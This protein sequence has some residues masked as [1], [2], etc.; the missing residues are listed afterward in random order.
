MRNERLRHA[1]VC[2]CFM[3]SGLAALVYQMTWTRQFA[4]VF[5]T[6]ELAVATVLAAYMGGL[7]LGARG[8]EWLLPRVR[9]PLRLYSHL[10]LAIALTAL[11]LVP[12]CLWLAERLIVAMLGGQPEPASSGATGNTVFYLL[13]AFATLLIPTTL[14]GATLPLLAR[15]G[16]LSE[17]QIG[18]RIGMLYACN[19]AGAVVGALF[20]AL[21]LLPLLGL[22]ATTWFAAA[23]NLAVFVLAT[24]LLRIGGERSPAPPAVAQRARPGRCSLPGD[25]WILPLILLSGAVSFLH[26]VLWTRLLQRVIGSSIQAFGVMVASFLL[27]IALGGALGARLATQRESAARWF[28]VSQIAVAVMAIVA[29]LA[30]LQ[31]GGVPRAQSTRVLFGL[32]LLLP[33][34]LAIGVTYP[35]AVRVLSTGV[36]D[37]AAA[38]ARVY[39][40]N[41]AGAIAGALVGGFVLVPALRYEGALRVAVLASLLLALGAGALLIRPRWREALPAL[42][43]IVLIAA[44][45]RPTVPERL[46][47]VSTLRGGKGELLHYS[48]GRS[49]DVVVVRDDSLLDLRTNGLP[50]AGSP[51]LGAA[52]TVNVEAW[53]SM[54]AVL[55]RPDVADM[56]IVGFGGGNVAQAVPPSVR[57]VD[58]IELEPRVIEANRAIAAV[59][60][61]D[62]L[63]D[64]RLN[65][66]T[67]DARGA[68]AL[69][70]KQYDAIVSQPSHPWT[71][72]AS[73]LYTR[74][75]MELARGHLRDG[76]VFVQWMGAEFTDEALLRSL[77][78]TLAAVFHEVRV[79]RPSSTT[80]IFMGSDAPLEPERRLPGIRATIERSPLHYARFGINAA[81]DMVTALALDNAGARRFAAGREPITD[82]DNRLA[83]AD[84]YERRLGM[85][86]E[87]VAKLLA[88]YDPLTAADSFIH[89][90]VAAQLS[91]DY[92]WRRA[93]LWAGSGPATLERMNK[94]ADLLGDTDQSQLLRF[95]MAVHLK[96]PEN[97][98][99]L[100]AEGLRRWPDSVPLQYAAAE[101][102]LT[103]SVP[104]EPA[105]T[106]GM[107]MQLPAEP[108]LVVTA[109]QHASQ[110]QW[111]A[112]ADADALLAKVPWT[113]QW[114][115]QA[116]QL[117]AEWRARVKNPEL[118]QRFG[119][120]GI[121]IADRALV[122]QPDMFWHALR[123]R[124]ASGTSRPEVMLESIAAF[125][126]T[127]EQTKQKLTGSERRLARDR[128]IALTGLIRQ[129]EGDSRVSAVRVAEVNKRLNDA[130]DALL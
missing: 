29:W 83:T 4:L 35:L 3:L 95:M 28:M 43:I 15:D 84:V 103:R 36:G 46:L 98:A 91:F 34:S 24:L 97:A 50:E 117:R 10:E 37:A 71:A 45:F 55:A 20:G 25:I 77:V 78:G 61:R 66:I 127:V 75:F 114:G 57:R 42:A 99:R 82:D 89:R 130:V 72:G 17:Q 81:E 106:A 74:E 129:L 1:L 40:W 100:L 69:T 33:L 101:A 79:Y 47:R 9:R 21:L 12:A 65:I 76:G 93:V 128:A 16:V 113:A 44:L 2:G 120:E 70:S 90:E 59:R 108:A 31:W 92:I 121:A 68:L 39:S 60:S 126:A 13:A 53:M 87:Q 124:S 49:A 54:M 7:A 119:D 41:T 94:L 26:E 22:R 30:L 51:V 14:M 118:R 56:L 96:Q 86:G 105:I 58:V 107:A 67:N 11:T 88:P 63:Q 73:H 123:A 62:P 116:A 38:S 5:G 102:Q 85:D 27:G 80:L 19:T 6:S 104:G 115:M 110:Q 112:V 125:C 32:L 64:A 52:P 111:N 18:S 48:V 23:V 8:I 109:T 122:T